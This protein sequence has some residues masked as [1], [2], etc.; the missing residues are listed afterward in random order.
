MVP[1]TPRV[2]Y[3]SKDFSTPF[4]MP[5]TPKKFGRFKAHVLELL[6]VGG[7]EA[8]ELEKSFQ[9][10]IGGNYV[11]NISDFALLC[12]DDIPDD[13]KAYPVLAQ[14]PIRRKLAMIM[15]FV[16]RGGEVTKETTLGEIHQACQEDRKLAAVQS[17]AMSVMTQGTTM[18]SSSVSKLQAA[19][20]PSFSGE[21]D[22]WHAWKVRCLNALGQAAATEFVEDPEI[23]D[24]RPKQAESIY[25]L[26]AGALQEGKA[27]W[28]VR[29]H[30]TLKDPY[31]L[32]DSLLNF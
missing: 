23:V 11:K 17:P 10:F 30:Q 18:D 32:W 15:E 4:D 2:S 27:S 16:S 26:I 6:D 22:D 24:Q 1:T 8:G 12:E 7:S 28:M 14:T 25:F 9:K 19:K 29:K 31:Q 20:I 21:D 13:I 5:N 3:A